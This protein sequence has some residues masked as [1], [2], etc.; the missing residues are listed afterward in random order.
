[1]TR[2]VT[3]VLPTYDERQTICSVIEAVRGILEDRDYEIVVVDDSPTSRTVDVVH[4]AYHHDARV[5]W[6][7]RGGSGLASAVLEGFDVAAGERYVVLD[8][9]GQH[10]PRRIVNLLHRL[11]AGAD[12]A[13]CSRHVDGGQVAGDWPTHRHLI[14]RGAEA[15]AQLAVPTAR[16]LSDPMSGYFAVEADVV[17]PVRERL[18]P[19][20]YKILLELVARCPVREIAEVPYTFEQRIDGASSLGPREYL[21]YANHLI[22]LTIPSRRQSVQ[23]VTP[24]VEHVD[25]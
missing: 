19:S 7:H 10:P 22:R 18:R 13:I 3:V 12:I 9:D 5:R 21:K 14:S 16:K 8:A 1:M 23:V 15:L 25:G 20:G 11:D 24:E 4:D 6:R 17:E 2:A